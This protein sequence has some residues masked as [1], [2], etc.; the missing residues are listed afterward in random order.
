MSTITALFQAGDASNLR[1]LIEA[2]S[3]LFKARVQ[4]RVAIANNRLSKCTPFHVLDTA[5]K[6]MEPIISPD[7]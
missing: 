2:I 5:T 4:W 1:I 3:G 7:Y 6:R